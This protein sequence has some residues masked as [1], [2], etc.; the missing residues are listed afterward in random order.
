MKIAL[1]QFYSKNPTPVYDELARVLRSKGHTVWVATPDDRGDLA[2]RDGAEILHRTRGPGRCVVP[3]L[4]FMERRVRQLLFML[5]VRRD[6]AGLRPDVAQINKSTYCGIIP[7]RKPLGIRFVFDVRQLGLWGDETP[8]GRRANR[9]V[10]RRV[11]RN[12]LRGYDIA[13]YPSDRAAQLVLGA[14]WPQHAIIA[15]IGVSPVFLEH[16]L[17]EPTPVRDRR[18]TFIYVGSLVRAKRLEGLLE[19]AAVAQR[20]GANLEL[21]LMGPGD[22]ISHYIDVIRRLGLE[23]TVQVRPPVPYK[24]VPAIV[25]AHDLAVAFVPTIEDWKYQVTLKILEYRALGVPI[26]A[27]DLPPNRG[28][29]RPGENGLLAGN[30]PEVFGAAMLRFVREPELLEACRAGARA[31][32]EGRTWSTVADVYLDRAYSWSSGQLVEAPIAS[33]SRG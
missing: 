14:N 4:R 17:P 3:G 8:R 5:R 1:L 22:G 11:R 10:L 2:W 31:V 24:D 20:G 23:G 30:A 32:R 6:V 33:S 26:L 9:R 28:I 18:V 21:T 13:C 25:A 16:R 19:A 29:V 12:S 27:S 15:P 7:W